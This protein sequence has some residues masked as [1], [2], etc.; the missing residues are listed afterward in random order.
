MITPSS[1]QVPD[2]KSKDPKKSRALLGFSNMSRG[3]SLKNSPSRFGANGTGREYN[4]LVKFFNVASSTFPETLCRH[5]IRVCGS[6]CS[7]PTS[8]PNLSASLCGSTIGA[9]HKL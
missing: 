3:G 5:S 7:Q 6:V 8:L 1:A 2:I 4:P 9:H